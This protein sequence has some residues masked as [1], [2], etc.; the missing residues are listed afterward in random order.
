MLE[1]RTSLLWLTLALLSGGVAGQQPT[2]LNISDSD[3][4]PYFLDRSV[5]PGG[6]FA[7]ELLDTCLGEAGY[8]LRYRPVSI[9][10]SY[11]GLRTGVVDLHIFS[12][13]PDREAFLAFGA[14]PLF[15]D[16]YQPIVLTSRTPAITK[17]SD[18]DGLRLGHLEG[19]RYDD[20]FLTYVRD[21]R[22]AGTVRV[23]NSNEELLELLVDGEI[24]VFVNLTSTA[25]W[26]A[27]QR[28]VAERIRVEPLVIKA[29]DYFL[30][31]S[32]SSRRIKQPEALLAA[33]DRCI[34]AMKADG[35]YR[36]L[37]RRYG[38]E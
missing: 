20:D 3:W 37:A 26:L 6:G 28:G 5:A 25:R 8:E 10:R 15:R 7:R 21:R 1:H 29:S 18:F 30:T 13:R 9:E 34:Q 16:A 27:R 12:L 22:N 23:A 33:A 2:I 24:D 32:K 36:E 11:E 38:L 14:E 31:A 4:P 17:V 35:R 19:L